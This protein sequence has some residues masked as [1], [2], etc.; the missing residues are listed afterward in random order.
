MK[1][2][3]LVAPGEVELADIP[4]PEPQP[5]EVLVRLRQAGICGTDYA[6]YTGSV[7]APLPL[8]LG[9]EAVGEVAARGAA[10][11][12]FRIGDRV[13]LQPNFACGVCDMCRGGR[14]NICRRKVR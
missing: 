1:A 5:K 3:L 12:R 9:H 6:V 13:T 14:T 11:S 7:R 8:V 10:P 4:A 2:A